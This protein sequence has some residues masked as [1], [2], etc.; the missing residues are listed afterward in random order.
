M[1]ILGALAA[2]DSMRRR[3]A[4]RI[5]CVDIFFVILSPDVLLRR[6]CLR[7]VQSSVQ[8]ERRIKRL[9]LVASVSLT[10]R[11]SGQMAYH[12]ILQE[13]VFF[14]LDVVLFDDHGL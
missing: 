6:I 9:I 13:N 14:T 5:G 12:A 2:V 8:T 11:C 10:E 4:A 1:V 3:F 7:R